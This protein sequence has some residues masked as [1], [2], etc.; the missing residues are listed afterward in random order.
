MSSIYALVLILPTLTYAGVVEN[1]KHMFQKMDA[2]GDGELTRKEFFDYVKNFDENHDL[3][4]SLQEQKNFIG[5]L[6]PDL[7]QYVEAWF[8]IGD[9]NHD[10]KF[11]QSEMDKSFAVLDY[12]KDGVDTESEFVR[13]VV[14]VVVPA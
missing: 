6:S 9:T 14:E 13:Y 12:N 8:P 2:D 3:G 10:G 5:S 4:L 7:V 11:D 1:A